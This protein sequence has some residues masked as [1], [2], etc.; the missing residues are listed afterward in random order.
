MSDLHD[1]DN[2]CMPPIYQRMLRLL[3]PAAFALMIGLSVWMPDPFLMNV[4]GHSLV[5]A[6]SGEAAKILEPVVAMPAAQQDLEMGTAPTRIW[7][8]RAWCAIKLSSVAIDA[9]VVKFVPADPGPYLVMLAFAILYTGRVAATAARYN[10]PDIGIWQS[11]TY[12]V[13]KE[14]LPLVWIGNPY[15]VSVSLLAALLATM[16]TLYRVITWGFEQAMPL[17]VVGRK[18]MLW[19]DIC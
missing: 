18:S 8:S 12:A 4:V 5:L 10:R 17:F 14:F 9:A 7:R 1:S 2:R 16:W 3:V 13:A 6:A 19:L 11:I 15:R